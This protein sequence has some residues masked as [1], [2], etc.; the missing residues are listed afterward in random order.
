[1]GLAVALKIKTVCPHSK[2]EKLPPS[3]PL[4]CGAQRAT[5]HCRAKATHSP[6]RSLP[7]LWPW[8]CM[9]GE[10]APPAALRLK[11]DS[12]VPMEGP[13]KRP[14]PWRHCLGWVER[15]AVCLN[16]W[17]E[18]LS[19]MARLMLRKNPVVVEAWAR[20][21]GVI[22]WAQSGVWTG[23]SCVNAG[24]GPATPRPRLTDS[25]APACSLLRGL[26]A[27]LCLQGGLPEL[28]LPSPRSRTPGATEQ[29]VL[30]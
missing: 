7:M 6:T 9:S 2:R 20:G 18:W 8:T 16:A 10:L 21:K 27:P 5:W 30:S 23:S 13:R 26:P 14:H 15:S 1:M 4:L 25:Q 11:E 22:G 17:C 28:P 19:L 3:T 24:A 29:R 12:A